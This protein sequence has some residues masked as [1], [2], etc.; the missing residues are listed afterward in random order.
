MK[1]RL[2]PAALLLLCC[3]CATEKLATVTPDQVSS[4]AVLAAPSKVGVIAERD[5]VVTDDSL[6]TVA[7]EN[8]VKALKASYQ[9]FADT[10]L[11]V[12][13][14]SATEDALAQMVFDAMSVSKR[15]LYTV[16]VPEDVLAF[17][18]G[19]G[20]RFVLVTLHDGFFRTKQNYRKEAV[21]GV[22]ISVASAILTGILSGGIYVDGGVYGPVKQNSTLS[23]ALVDTEEGRV[24]Y[25]RSVDSEQPPHE[26][27]TV[28]WQ[29]RRVLEKY[30]KR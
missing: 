22:A 9:V 27:G 8:V 11:V 1:L 25:A 28:E 14:Y 12:E 30:F 13:P 26:Y 6:V 10:V 7:T 17:G 20:N 16:P 19:T 2:L 5:M 4:V 15:K 18:R 29:V 23:A 21:K 24:L 3:S